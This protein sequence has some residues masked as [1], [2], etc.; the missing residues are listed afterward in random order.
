MLQ[1][2]KQERF[3]HVYEQQNFFGGITVISS[4]GTFDSKR[5]GSKQIFCDSQKEVEKALQSIKQ[6]RLKRWYIPYQRN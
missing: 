3:Y 4:W 6:T 2:K 1:F 5:G